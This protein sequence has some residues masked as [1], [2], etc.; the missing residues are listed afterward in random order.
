MG[1]VQD[2]G[3]VDRTVGTG[4]AASHGNRVMY[5]VHIHT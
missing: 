4:C 3:P 1:C 2:L 5:L